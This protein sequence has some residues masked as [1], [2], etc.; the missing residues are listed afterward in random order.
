MGTLGSW[1]LVPC[2]RGY[3]E[4]GQVQAYASVKVNYHNLVLPPSDTS[5]DLLA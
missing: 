1:V 4:T 5:T 3:E 2:D